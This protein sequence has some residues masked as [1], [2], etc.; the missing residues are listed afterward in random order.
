MKK[1][2]LKEA[3]MLHNKGFTTRQLVPGTDYYLAY[4]PEGRVDIFVSQETIRLMRNLK[5]Y[6]QVA[7]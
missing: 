2:P 5:K 6:A 7:E 4:D 3:I 1:N